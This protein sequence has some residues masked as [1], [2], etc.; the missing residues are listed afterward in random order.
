MGND[1]KK[2]AIETFTRKP[3]KDTAPDPE[4]IY[5]QIMAAKKESLEESDQKTDE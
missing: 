5:K 2:R 4:E 1:K 3:Q